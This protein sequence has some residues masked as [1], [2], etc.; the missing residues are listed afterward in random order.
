MVLRLWRDMVEKGFGSYNLVSDALFDLLC[1]TGKLEE[2]E[3]C[4]WEMIEK[5]QKPCNVSFRRIKVLMKLRIAS[6]KALEARPLQ[7][8]QSSV[9]QNETPGDQLHRCCQ[10]IL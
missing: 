7:L 8:H 10:S 2:E 4:L 3:K 9:S 1:D 5:G 6:H